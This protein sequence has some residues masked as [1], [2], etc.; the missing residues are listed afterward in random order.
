M[1]CVDTGEL[2]A[3]RYEHLDMQ[4]VGR[5][6]DFIGMFKHL[7]HGNGRIVL[8]VSGG[9]VEDFETQTKTPNRRKKHEK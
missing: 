6:N 3:I 8:T 9:Y 1:H 7:F 2:Q 5:L 4:T